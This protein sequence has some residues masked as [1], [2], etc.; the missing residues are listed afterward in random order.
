MQQPAELPHP[1]PLLGR[2]VRTET[3]ACVYGWA[4]AIESVH[5]SPSA[6]AM[7]SRRR[8]LPY[9]PSSSLPLLPGLSQLR[10]P[11]SEAPAPE[12]PTLKDVLMT[13][14]LGQLDWFVVYREGL[15]AHVTRGVPPP[16]Y[17]VSRFDE[18]ERRVDALIREGWRPAPAGWAA[19]APLDSP[20]PAPPPP[21]PHGLPVR[22]LRSARHAKLKDTLMMA[23]LG[24][25]GWFVEYRKELA[26]HREQGA[27]APEYDGA[28]FDVVERRVDTLI[29]EVVDPTYAR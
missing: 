29:R 6:R 11:A 26:A 14:L 2:V 15:A 18:V 28:L 21:P 23:L 9:A 5:S 24:E 7:D 10:R 20:R 25:L 22:Q 16:T 3:A 1:H 4:H 27:T 13:T 19:A 8:A 12:P 17:D